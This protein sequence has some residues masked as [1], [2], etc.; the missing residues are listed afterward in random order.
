MSIQG[1]F[2]SEY[3][4]YDSLVLGQ[5]CREEKS[6][7]TQVSTNE[8]IPYKTSPH[9]RPLLAQQC[10]H[11][12]LGFL[13]WK[14]FCGC[15]YL[16]SPE[17]RAWNRDL[18]VG[19]VRD[20]DNETGKV[21]HPGKGEMSDWV[22]LW[23]TEA[24]RPWGPSKEP[25]RLILRLVP[26]RRGGWDEPAWT[27]WHFIVMEESWGRASGRCFRNLSWEVAP[28]STNAKSWDSQRAGGG[29]RSPETPC[30]RGWVLPRWTCVWQTAGHTVT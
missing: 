2:L 23:M 26:Q 22:S 16:G 5:L 1:S 28:P 29:V 17:S 15:L 19:G 24:Q 11:S 18:G 27:G 4:L 13:S 7:K 14:C 6:Q 9:S 25:C 12:R 3:L 8:L 30:S 10:V 20:G 21:G